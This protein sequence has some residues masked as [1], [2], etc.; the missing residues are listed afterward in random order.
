MSFGSE[1]AQS[2]GLDQT[3]FGNATYFEIAQLV[4]PVDHKKLGFEGEVREDLVQ[5]FRVVFLQT[6]DILRTGQPG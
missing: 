1:A 4:A 5:Y 2:A 6:P 3:V